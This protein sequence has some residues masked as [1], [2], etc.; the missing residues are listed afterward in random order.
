[1]YKNQ[2]QEGKVLTFSPQNNSADLKP[3]LGNGGEG[4]PLKSILSDESIYIDDRFSFW[5]T[6]EK[7]SFKL[8]PTCLLDFG[9]ITA[10]ELCLPYCVCSVPAGFPTHVDEAFWEELDLARY[11]IKPTKMSYYLKVAG[12]SMAESGIFHGDI[13]IIDCALAPK[14]GSIVTVLVNGELTIRRLHLEGT[15]NIFL[16]VSSSYEEC[17]INDQESLII[18]GVVTSIIRVFKPH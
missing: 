6:D 13:L 18:Q 10:Q 14:N 8:D 3:S 7:G 17:H 4:S 11:L 2:K 5:R 12:D 9:F 15:K 16:P 1:M